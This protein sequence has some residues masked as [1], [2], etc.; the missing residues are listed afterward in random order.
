MPQGYSTF[1]KDILVAIKLFFS[2]CYT[3]IFNPDIK[4]LSVGV[5]EFILLYWFVY[6]AVV[7]M[8]PLNVFASMINRQLFKHRLSKTR[9]SFCRYA[10]I[11]GKIIE[12]ICNSSTIIGFYCFDHTNIIVCVDCF[13]CSTQSTKSNFAET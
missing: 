2:L 6:V 5:N 4:L 11:D 12:F 13:C 10:T 7:L 8:L 3:T 1:L 9:N